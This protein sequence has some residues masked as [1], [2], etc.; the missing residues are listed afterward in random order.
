M[1]PIPN[2]PESL[3]H[4]AL[5]Y[6][7]VAIAA[8]ALVAGTVLAA[9]V[10]LGGRKLARTVDVRVVPV[11]YS[12]DATALRHGRYLFETRGCGECHGMDGRGRKL[13]DNEGMQVH[14]PNLTAG[15]GSAVAAYNEGD[16]V[17]AIR[18]GVDPRGRALFLMPSEDYNR[19]TDVDLAALVGYTRSLPPVDGEA[20]LVRLPLMVK[21]FYGL[22]VIPDAAQKID[23]R[24]PPSQPVPAA[25][26]VE[27][28]A[29]VA[30]MCKGCH[31]ASFSGG[32]VMGAPPE[33]P[34]ASNLT[35][36]EG[37]VM[38]RY[39]SIEKFAAMLRTGKRPDGSAVSSAM[40]FESLRNLNEVDVR[41]MHAFLRALPARRTGEH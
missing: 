9:G 22:G 33:W 35:P 7:L 2:L 23:H 15:R 34:P 31:N 16:W 26:T 40:P 10:W 38:A 3:L 25:A 5:K 41:A 13:I 14:A 19:M 39:D 4:K 27:H 12:R 32:R 6:A 21:A 18:H 37:G 1:P 29:Y 24:L 8:L 28:G 17:R 11:P 30:N 20:A 36:G